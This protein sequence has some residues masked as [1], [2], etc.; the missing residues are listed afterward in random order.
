MLWKLSKR[1]INDEKMRGTVYNGVSGVSDK[2]GSV[3]VMSVMGASG[4][5]LFNKEVHIFK[6]FSN[7]SKA[8]LIDKK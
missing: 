8:K 3:D 2:R 7:N 5:R 4:V 1:F 6:S